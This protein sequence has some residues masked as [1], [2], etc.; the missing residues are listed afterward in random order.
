[1]SQVVAKTPKTRSWLWLQGLLCGGG[2]S[3]FPAASL[4]IVALFAPAVLA[5]LSDRTAKRPVG[6]AMMMMAAASAISPLHTLIQDSYSIDGALAIISNPVVLSV[7]WL[8][9]A[10][11]WI[12]SEATAM[13]SYE[14]RTV[15]CRHQVTT[16]TNERLKLSQ[17]WES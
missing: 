14:I 5:F 7:S 10:A 12:I 8:A 17:E 9:S 16:L 13:A 11:G 2:L 1:M 15:I 4:V 3:L 6:T